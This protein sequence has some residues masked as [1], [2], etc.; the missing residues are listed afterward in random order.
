[1]EG[2]QNKHP[3][4]FAGYNIVRAAP[5]YSGV[6]GLL[7]GFALTAVVFAITVAGT[8][9]H[10]SHAQKIDVG[11]ATTMFAVAFLGCLV[12][13]YS[14]ASLA[15]EK[16]SPAA[17][18]CSMLVGS[19]IA[20]CFIAI[21]GGF[22]ALARAFL[23]EST[24][25]FLAVCFVGV[26]VA[27]PFVWFPQWDIVRNF[28]EPPHAGPPK[29]EEE[30]KR[31]VIGLFI[32]GILTALSGYVVRQ[33]AILGTGHHWEYLA[34]ALVALIYTAAMVLAALVVAT[35]IDRPRTSVRMTWTLGLIQ[36]ATFLAL[37][38]LV[39]A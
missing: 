32:L 36:S 26:V 20:V 7:S 18:T 35:W 3:E 14:L 15:G 30:A 13:A 27:P 28:G 10:L 22:A 11:F 5:S 25:A 9:R 21:L 34:L 12:C 38:C 8:D 4:G 37:I 19:G 23:P 16:N 17:L 2:G 1:M 39:P 6:T 29:S 33:S 31:L 24:P